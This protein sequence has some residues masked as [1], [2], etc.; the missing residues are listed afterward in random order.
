MV[1]VDKFCH[2]QFPLSHPSLSSTYSGAKLDMTAASFENL[3]NAHIAES[4]I[5]AATGEPRLAGG[6][7]P[8]CKHVFIPND[9]HTKA[10]VNTIPVTAL[11]EHLLRTE[12]EARTPQELP[13]LSRFFP[14]GTV[15]EED[16]PIATFIDVILYSREQI[17]KENAA[18]GDAPNDETAPWG[19]V[20]I[21]PQVVN[22][23]LPMN[24]ITAM[25]NA[26][27]EEHGGSGKPIDRKEYMEAVEFW[28]A[29]AVVK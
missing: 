25:R 19:V 15:K 7:A 1:S 4:C 16:L 27:G 2:R 22:R 21:K 13:V 3:V 18:T 6:Y 26:L 11:N 5:D 24:P 17:T 23:E 8:F 10:R 14:K 9:G 29:N 12:Y 20:S 28:N